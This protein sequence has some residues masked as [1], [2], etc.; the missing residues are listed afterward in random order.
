MD[1]K[2]QIIPRSKLECIYHNR[3]LLGESP[4]W[5]VD[6][7]CLYWVDIEGRTFNNFNTSTSKNITINT[8]IRVSALALRE[9]GGFI[10]ATETGFQFYNSTENS[11]TLIGDPESNKPN[12]RFNDGR[13]DR[14]GR[15]WAGTMIEKGNQIPDAGLYSINQDLNY[16]KKCGGLI[17]SNGLAW[18]PN[19]RTMYLAD[20]RY[21]VVWAFD[22]DIDNGDICNQRKFI[23]FDLDDGVPDGATIDTDGC[24]WLAQPRASRICRY[25]PKGRK[26]TIVEL[27][28]SKPTM[29]AFGGSDL[30]ILYITTSSLGLSEKE[31]EEQPLAGSLLGLDVKAQ[32]LPEPKFIN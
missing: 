15:F 18:S 20:T 19:N 3:A 31:L 4:V 28:V 14:A 21:P 13:C 2:M 9:P 17:L 11:F 1:T 5:S 24:Y 22:F 23:E 10:V 32:G 12:N 29:C 26:D 30:N 7:K 25:T 27:P 8:G 16:K 6:E